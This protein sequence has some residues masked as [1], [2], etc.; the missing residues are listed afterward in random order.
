MEGNGHSLS[1]YI[2][3]FCLDGP[4]KITR[5]LRIAGLLAEI[6]TLDLPNQEN[7]Q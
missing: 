2:L 3:E 5:S 6:W 4:R 1:E 7:D